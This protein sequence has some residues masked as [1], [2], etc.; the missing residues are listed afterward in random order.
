MKLFEKQKAVALRKKGTSIREISR[1][2]GVSKGSVSVW[3][4]DVPLSKKQLG[5]LKEK[6]FSSEAIEKRRQ[7]RLMNE[8]VK[9]DAIAT[10]AQK[11]I[12]NISHRDLRIIGLCLYWGEGGKTRQGSARI[13]NSDPAVIKVMM[14]FFRE[15]FKVEEKKFR[16]HIHIHSHLNIKSAERYWSHVSGIPRSQFF[17]TYSKPSIASKN[18]KDNLPYGTFDIYVCN[19]KLFLQIIA[20]IEKIK[21][22]I[23]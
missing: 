23:A 18:K 19:T 10:L 6:G 4:R 15:I 7:K 14:R 21:K 20:Q 13:S 1:I 12:R 16:G 5:A 9:R 8:Q 3:V 11:D 17:K 22:L 2:I